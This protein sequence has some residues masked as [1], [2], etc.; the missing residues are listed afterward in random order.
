MPSPASFIVVAAGVF[1]NLFQDGPPAE[2]PAMRRYEP[3]AFPLEL[4][5]SALLDGYATAAFTVDTEGK[6]LD[7]VVLETNHPAFGNALADAIREWQLQVADSATV[8]RR[9]VVR[10]IFMR[11]GKVG[12][13]SH[14]EAAR[15]AFL[16]S[17]DELPDTTTIT[18][19]QLAEKPTRIRGA[20]PAYPPELKAAGVM[21]QVTVN[22][23]I[24][25]E[26][27][28]RVAVAMKTAHPEL[29]AA[30]ITAV[31][32]WRFEPVQRAGQTVLVEDTRTFTFGTAR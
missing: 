2:L 10:F 19:D 23:I 13:Y 3:P 9:E 1:G 25:G 29:G 22:Y 28:A 16:P 17:E 4:R 7:V 21:G 14:R 32:G 5:S 31:Q 6:I 8:P 26:G 18:W 27:R 12:S 15:A 30:A 20:A 24:D 11:T